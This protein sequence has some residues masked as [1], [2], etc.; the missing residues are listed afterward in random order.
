MPLPVDDVAVIQR[1][2]HKLNESIPDHV[3]AQLRDET[4]I[5]R[6]AVTLIECRLVDLDKPD[7]E[8][9]RVPIARLRFFRPSGWELFWPDRNSQFHVY[10]FTATTR[11]V[12]TLLREIDLDPMAIFFG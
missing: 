7:G 11:Q 10:E 5:Y 3:L 6:N 1:W 8:W 9:F 12:Q 4:E 2:V